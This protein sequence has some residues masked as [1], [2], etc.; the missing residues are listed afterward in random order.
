MLERSCVAPQVG[1]Q[2][3]APRRRQLSL[4]MSGTRFYLPSWLLD[5]SLAHISSLP[6]SCLARLQVDGQQAPG[7]PL[8]MIQVL[9]TQKDPGNPH[10]SP[11]LQGLADALSTCV[12]PRMVGCWAW[13]LCTPSSCCCAPP[14]ARTDGCKAGPRHA[15]LGSS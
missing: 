1:I 10:S 8:Q 13:R 5:S 7:G 15:A 3:E 2:E 12:G 4:K 11:Y 14:A 9:I 6:H